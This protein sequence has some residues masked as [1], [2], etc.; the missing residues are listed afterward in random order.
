MPYDYFIE[1]EKQAGADMKTALHLT[2]ALAC[3]M[4]MPCA[5]AQSIFPDSTDPRWAPLEETFLVPY[6]GELPKLAPPKTARLWQPFL[7]KDSGAKICGDVLD[8]YVSHYLSSAAASQKEPKGKE[9]YLPDYTQASLFPLYYHENRDPETHPWN[10]PEVETENIYHD[11]EDGPKQFA[12]LIRFKDRPNDIFLH[13]RGPGSWR[14]ESGGYYLFDARQFEWNALKS[15][16]ANTQNM[17]EYFPADRKTDGVTQKGLLSIGF[18]TFAQ[19]NSIVLS[20]DFILP[21][22]ILLWSDSK[23]LFFIKRHGGQGSVQSNEIFDGS[24]TRKDYKAQHICNVATVD[25][26]AD[27]RYDRIG[28]ARDGQDLDPVTDPTALDTPLR[29]YFERVAQMV[30]HGHGQGGTMGTYSRNIYRNRSLRQGFFTRPWGFTNRPNFTGY[31]ADTAEKLRRW[32]YQDA[33]SRHVYLDALSRY[34]DARSDAADYLSSAYS[35]PLPRAEDYAQNAITAIT[36]GHFSF[37]VNALERAGIFAQTNPHIPSIYE[38]TIS[39]ANYEIV[40]EKARAAAVLAALNG[41]PQRNSYRAIA[42]LHDCLT[43]AL[44]HDDLFSAYIGGGYN[45]NAPNHFGKTPLMVAAHLD[46][47]GRVQSLI[48]AGADIHTAIP[49]KTA[50][51]M[52]QFPKRPRTALDYALE[53]GSWDTIYA[54]MDAG[55]RRAEGS[56]SIMNTKALLDLNPNLSAYGR[57]YIAGELAFRSP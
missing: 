26:R 29:R 41:T 27:I 43:A 52:N 28:Y 12:Q 32:S 40:L 45:V 13:H 20:Q 25:N 56:E 38:G 18:E 4:I 33:W 17:I 57:A 8:Y 16:L 21:N 9:T 7:R 53:N 30:G 49:N 50:G 31:S 2:L 23:D 39:I 37:D 11:W 44:W 51:Q 42:T 46:F 34:G 47:G 1:H 3:A 19:E 6:E 36:L 48:D 54:L 5:A 22:L 35:G 10:G 14:G 15:K 24:V 55:A